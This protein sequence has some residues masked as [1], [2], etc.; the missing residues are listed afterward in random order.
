[1]R[2]ITILILLLAAPPLQAAPVLFEKDIRPILKAHCFHCHGE[3]GRERGDL[4][5]RLRRLLLE[6][7]E[8]GPAIVEGKPEESRLFQMVESG[9]M[10]KEQAKLSAEEIA[11]IREWIAQG[12][13]T[14]RP[15]PGDPD[16]VGITAE[17][18][19]FWAFQPIQNPK[20]PEGA[21]H[22]IDAFLLRRLHTKGLSLSAAADK[23]TLIRRATVDLTGLPPTPEET[24]KFIADQ[25]PDAYAKLIDRLLTSPQYGVRWGR[26][27]LD[28]AGYADSEGYNEKDTERTWA[29]RYRDYV[30][31]AFNK[32]LPWDQFIREQLA[33]DEMVKPPHTELQPT[34]STSS[35]P[36]AISA[37][38]DGTGT[39]NNNDARN[40]VMAET[41][42]IVSSSLMGMTVGCAQ[43]HDHRYDPIPQKDYYQIRAIF[44]PGSTPRAGACP[45]AAASRSTPMPTATRPPRL[46]RGQKG[47]CRAPKENRVFHRAHLTWK[48]EAA[49]EGPRRTPRSLPLQETHRPAEC[50]SEKIPER[51]ADQRRFAVSLRPRVQRRNQQAQH[52][53][54]KVCR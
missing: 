36:P 17:E 19:S 10:P 37:W 41:L 53:A 23:A 4:D 46:R 26:H 51:T 40:Q 52:R 30:V 39:A 3:D 50:H 6:G 34:K 33:G 49:Q 9:K 22:P 54:E 18:R 20:V 11:L 5:V 44:E 1:M 15:E 25:S 28:V 48:L 32:D 38:P 13:K 14:A 29:W 21:K 16:T 27:W 43:C 31:N 12:A 42:K 45:T 47:R 2:F 7:G 8:H 35:P 24:K